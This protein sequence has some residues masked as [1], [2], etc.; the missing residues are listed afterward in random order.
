MPR[1]ISFFDLAV[2]PLSAGHSNRAELCPEQYLFSIHLFNLQ[3]EKLASHE[4]NFLFMPHE[5]KILLHGGEGEIR[6]LGT[7]S[8]TAV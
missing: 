3:A 6:T 1:T 2:F 5:E 7:V 4:V 8:S